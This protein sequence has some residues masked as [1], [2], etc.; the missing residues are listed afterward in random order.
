MTTLCL[1]LGLGLCCNCEYE[2]LLMLLPNVRLHRREPA[3]SK[4]SLEVF[5]S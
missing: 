5:N 1:G 4:E 2:R 3:L